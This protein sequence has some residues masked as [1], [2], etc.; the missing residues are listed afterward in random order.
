MQMWNP[1]FGL[2]VQRVRLVWDAQTVIALRLMKLGL[3][4]AK[5]QSEAQ[6]MVSEKFAAFMEAQV[7]VA[8]AAMMGYSGDRVAKKVF[9]VYRKRVRR[10]RRRLAR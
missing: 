8:T 10:N 1:W 9:G 4:G 3:G 2:S 6:R 5:A 7:G